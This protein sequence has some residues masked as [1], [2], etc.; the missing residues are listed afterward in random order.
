[1]VLDIGRKSGSELSVFLNWF[2]I[3]LRIA[4]AFSIPVN[5]HEMSPSREL[6]EV[7]GSEDPSGNS[8][9]SFE[10]LDHTAR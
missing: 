5:N 8:N 2:R 9:P 3:A 7:A 1:M 10:L 6:T 4:L